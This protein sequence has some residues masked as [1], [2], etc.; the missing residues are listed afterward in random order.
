MVLSDTVS[1]SFSSL[2]AHTNLLRKF[3]SEYRFLTLKPESD[4]Y[5]QMTLD[6]SPQVF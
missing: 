3:V 6:S 2:A 5:K 4:A 1:L